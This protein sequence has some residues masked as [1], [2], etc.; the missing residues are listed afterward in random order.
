MNWQQACADKNLQN[1]PFKIELNQQGQL[2]MSPVKV[3]HSLFQGKLSGLLY[4]NLRDGEALA[5]C[6]IR[7][8]QGTKVADVAWVSHE[9]LP[10][11]RYETECSQAPEICIEVLSESNTRD[12]M[13]EK[14]LLYLDAGALEVWLCDEDGNIRFYSATGEQETSM[15]APNFPRHI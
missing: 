9:R 4:F 5:E 3:S 10:R 2:V 13:Q 14:I 12:E 1:L 15:L 11:I 6:A 8:K 7:T